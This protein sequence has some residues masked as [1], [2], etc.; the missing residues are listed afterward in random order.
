MGW[1]YETRELCHGLYA[2]GYRLA[3]GE[4]TQ[5]TTFHCAAQAQRFADAQNKLFDCG[6]FLDVIKERSRGGGGR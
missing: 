4:W 3:D 1:R 6:G 5:T 2:V